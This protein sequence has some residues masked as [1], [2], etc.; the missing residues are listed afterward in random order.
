MCMR[1]NTHTHGVNKSNIVVDTII[2]I[3]NI[4]RRLCVCSFINFNSS[5]SISLT[6]MIL[7]KASPNPLSEF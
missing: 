5:C 3:I 4:S 2:H 1:L 7:K 6:V